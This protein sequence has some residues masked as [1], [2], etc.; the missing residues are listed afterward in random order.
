MK[1][2]TKIKGLAN[3]MSGTVI[4]ITPTSKLFSVV[5]VDICPILWPTVLKRLSHWKHLNGLSSVCVLKANS[6]TSEMVYFDLDINKLLPHM[7]RQVV[8]L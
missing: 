6:F 1:K 2:K 8:A 7:I 4:Q 3:K 5:C